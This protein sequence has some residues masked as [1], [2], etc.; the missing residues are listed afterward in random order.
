VPDRADLS[1]GAVEPWLSVIGR[2]RATVALQLRVGTLEGAIAGAHVQSSAAP[3]AA[4]RAGNGPCHLCGYAAV[5]PHRGCTPAEKR[6]SSATRCRTPSGGAAR[7]IRCALLAN[8]SSPISGDGSCPTGARLARRLGARRA[9]E[10]RGAPHHRL[11]LGR[12]DMPAREAS[13]RH[14]MLRTRSQQQ[15]G[16]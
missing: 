6:G 5:P 13:M 9:A 4:D 10:Q 12:R 2:G 7:N 11:R 16:A 1:P 3:T 15:T 8:R 14:P